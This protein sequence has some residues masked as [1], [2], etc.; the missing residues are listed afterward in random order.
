MRSTGQDQQQIRSL[1]QKLH[2]DLALLL[3][4]LS[5]MALGL[6]IVYSAGGHSIDIV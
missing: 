5:L 3:G 2:I 6:F 1:W 4:I